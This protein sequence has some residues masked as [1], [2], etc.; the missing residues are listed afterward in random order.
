MCLK[1]GG[2]I[3]KSRFFQCFSGSGAGQGAM[4][5]PIV[6]MYPR[7]SPAATARSSPRPSGTPRP[8]LLLGCP[9]VG[10][11]RPQERAKHSR[12]FVREVL[13]C[14]N[15]RAPCECTHLHGPR[16]VLPVLA[17]ERDGLSLWN[18]RVAPSEGPSHRFGEG[19]PI[20]LKVCR[21]VMQIKE[22]FD[23]A[24]PIAEHHHRF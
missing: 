22:V 8:V 21:E 7:R 15:A 5:G 4:D 1:G 16:R 13:R 2:L 24:V 19:R 6:P 10:E 3:Q 12:A 14:R 11:H 18:W 17:C 9:Q 20:K 23:A